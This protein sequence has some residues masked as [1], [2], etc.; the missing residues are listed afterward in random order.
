MDDEEVSNI[1][2]PFFFL[3]V[4]ILDPGLFECDPVILYDILLCFLYC[5]VFCFY[6]AGENQWAPG[7]SLTCLPPV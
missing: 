5:F 3:L 2:F 6:H 7:F 1:M 4:V